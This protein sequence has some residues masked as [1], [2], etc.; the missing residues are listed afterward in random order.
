VYFWYLDTDENMII[1]TQPASICF[2][3]PEPA[4]IRRP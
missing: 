2:Q 4:G 1:H 3:P